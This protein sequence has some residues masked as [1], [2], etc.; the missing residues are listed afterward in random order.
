MSE[1][2]AIEMLDVDMDDI[3][4]VQ[5]ETAPAVK[6]RPFD[7]TLRLRQ[8]EFLAQVKRATASAIEKVRNDGGKKFADLRATAAPR[9]HR[10]G[11]PGS[12]AVIDAIIAC[13]LTPTGAQQTQTAIRLRV[14]ANHPDKAVPKDWTKPLPAWAI[15]KLKTR[16][17]GSGVPFTGLKPSANWS[18]A[19]L[20]REAKAAILKEKSGALAGPIEVCLAA[21]SVVINGTSYKVSVSRTRGKEY[22]YVR[23]PV[24][25]LRDALVHC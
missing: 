23:I 14:A 24:D 16:V 20:H 18:L 10:A 8:A 21:N 19:R 22:G 5:E 6:R 12:G 25:A 11:L 1:Q 17:Q 4:L 15:L 13:I 2:N 3:S 9:V 7:P